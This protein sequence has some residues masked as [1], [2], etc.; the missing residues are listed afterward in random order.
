MTLQNG[1]PD[2]L[3]KQLA[4]FNASYSQKFHLKGSLRIRG[5]WK[6]SCLPSVF[7]VARLHALKIV[8]TRKQDFTARN[9][10][11]KKQKEQT[12]FLSHKEAMTSF[13]VFTA[14]I[15]RISF[16]DTPHRAQWITK[17]HIIVDPW[18]NSC[19][20]RARKPPCSAAK[21]IPLKVPLTCY[22]PRSLSI[23]CDPQQWHHITVLYYYYYMFDN[24]GFPCRGDGWQRY[25]RKNLICCAFL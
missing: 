15:I 6:R 18:T 25:F 9:P 16:R 24:S 2:T 1:L 21:E 14:W 19:W 5:V 11:N 20:R 13:L 10:S 22:R 8:G 3:I 17:Y 4:L 7:F 12:A 23:H